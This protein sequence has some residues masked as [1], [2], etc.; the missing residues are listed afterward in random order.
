MKNIPVL[1]IV[2]FAFAGLGA[3]AQQFDYTLKSQWSDNP[4]LHKVA[5][6]LVMN[7]TST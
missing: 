1:L 7:I 4:V 5:N 2:A 6:D 3:K